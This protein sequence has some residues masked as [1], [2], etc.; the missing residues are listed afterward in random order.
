VSHE[1]FHDKWENDVPHEMNKSRKRKEH[2]HNSIQYINLKEYQN[3]VYMK[4]SLENVL[5]VIQRM[6]SKMKGNTME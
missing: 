5:L 3:K 2:V 1:V 4:N 6:I